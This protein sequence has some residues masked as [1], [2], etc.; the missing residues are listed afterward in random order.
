VPL[1]WAVVLGID[2]VPHLYDVLVQD[3][4]RT[5]VVG[6]FGVIVASADAGSTWTLRHRGVESLFAI[7]SGPGRVLWCMGQ[8]GALLRSFDEGVGWE[9]R[10]VGRRVT[11]LGMSMGEDGRAVLLGLGT[12][13]LTGNGG[14]TWHRSPDLGLPGSWYQAVARTPHGAY[15]LSGAHG[16]I[17]RLSPEGRRP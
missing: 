10:D 15:L 2:D 14:R 9:K 13:L 12:V 11:L 16:S 6:E 17:V 4:L 7:A 1:D 3:S 5:L 8:D